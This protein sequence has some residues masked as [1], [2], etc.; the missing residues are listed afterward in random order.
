M[1]RPAVTVG[2]GALGS[3]AAATSIVVDKKTT[4]NAGACDGFDEASIVLAL[5]GLP[6]IV[7]VCVH[8]HASSLYKTQALTRWC[9][10]IWRKTHKTPKSVTAGIVD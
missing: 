3:L 10:R 6:Q 5:S 4:F 1:V 8:A 2:G 9:C 7:G